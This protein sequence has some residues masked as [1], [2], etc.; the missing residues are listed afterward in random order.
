MIRTCSYLRDRRGTFA[1]ALVSAV[2]VIVPVPVWGQWTGTDPVYTYSKVGI[3]TN[4]PDQAL[5]I[6]GTGATRLIITGGSAYAR[7]VAS[8]TTAY[9][10]GAN[11]GTGTILQSNGVDRLVIRSELSSLGGIGIVSNFG[12]GG[13]FEGIGFHIDPNVLVNCSMYSLLG[14]GG[15]TFLNAPTYNMYFSV[16]NVPKMVLNY[17]GNVGIGTNSP[18]YKLAVNGNIGAQDIIVTNN[19]WSDYVLRP[20]Y[21]L[22]PLSEVRRYIQANG[23]LP[24][25]PTEAEVKE[26]G[27]SLGDMQAKLLAKIEELT[28]HMIQ[29]EERNDR[30]ENQN[31]GLRERIARLEKAAAGDSEK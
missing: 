30:L 28:L 12:C 7:M 31:R 9:Y 3:G 4:A 27:V 26:K 11:N 23:H 15:N 6:S 8:G 14:D 24:D 25:I 17:L 22:R 18:Q 19:G 13:T 1:A 16:G 2:M 10:G 20:G 21:R 5:H 29:A